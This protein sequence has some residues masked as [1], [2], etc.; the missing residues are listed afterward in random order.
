MRILSPPHKEKRCLGSPEALQ[1]VVS[2]PG[3]KRTGVDIGRIKC[4][5][6]GD[7]WMKS[8]PDS[9]M[10]AKAYTITSNPSRAALVSAEKFDRYIGVLIVGRKLL[11]VLELVPPVGSRLVICENGSEGFKLVIDL[12]DRDK[13]SVTAQGASHSPNRT[14]DLEDL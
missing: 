12:R 3:A 5:D 13:I 7:V 9:K 11:C 8:R 6:G 1:R 2:L 10:S 14:G 4:T